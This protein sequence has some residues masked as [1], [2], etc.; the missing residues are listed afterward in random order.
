MSTA[1]AASVRAKGRRKSGTCDETATVA[2][3]CVV[4]MLNAVNGRY[5]SCFRF[6]DDDDDDED[7]DDEDDDEE[8]DDEDDDA[9]DESSSSPPPS[10]SLP[11]PHAEPTHTRSCARIRLSGVCRGEAAAAS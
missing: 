9:D 10:S 8:D 4:V 7:D 3:S 6:F 11:P 5:S 1:A 2:V